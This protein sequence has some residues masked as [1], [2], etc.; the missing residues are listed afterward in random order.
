MAKGKAHRELMK[1]VSGLI[2]K[3]EDVFDEETFYIFAI[4]IVVLSII[5]A[6]V[7]SR[8]ITLRDVDHKDD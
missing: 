3:F 1:Q 7:A 4:I 8:Y 6:I 2:P 5:A